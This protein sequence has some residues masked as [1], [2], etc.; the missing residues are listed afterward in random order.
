MQQPP[1]LRKDQLQ[2]PKDVAPALPEGYGEEGR[3]K[4]TTSKKHGEA[5]KEWRDSQGAYYGDRVTT[6]SKGYEAPKPRPGMR[7][8]S[9][10]ARGGPGFNKPPSEP[11]IVALSERQRRLTWR[12]K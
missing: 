9:P 5:N 1:K 4:F 11:N 7:P 10:L 2:H 8:G 6:T 12:G 3:A